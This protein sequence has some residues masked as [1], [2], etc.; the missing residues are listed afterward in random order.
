M[1]YNLSMFPVSPFTMD[2]QTIFR[3]QDLHV[4]CPVCGMRFYGLPLVLKPI[5][6]VMMNGAANIK[7]RSFAV[8]AIGK[9]ACKHL[10]CVR[11]AIMSSPLR[12]FSTQHRLTFLSS[13][14]SAI[15]PVPSSGH[16]GFPN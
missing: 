12:Q 14:R 4:Q 5:S 16:Y 9:A 6:G 15:P 3:V 13:L 8:L 11:Y 10:L 2:D 7:S 1:W